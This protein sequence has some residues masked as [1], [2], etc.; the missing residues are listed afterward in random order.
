M[1]ICGKIGTMPNKDSYLKK[2]RMKMSKKVNE[3]KILS[4]QF[5]FAGIFSMLCEKQVICKWPGVVF[6]LKPH[7][8]WM[9]L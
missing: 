8:D 9:V 1:A 5:Y 6:I 4:I 2:G 3:K 7:T